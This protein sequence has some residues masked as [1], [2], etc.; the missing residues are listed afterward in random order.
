M[1]TSIET[2]A[3]AASNP[4]PYICV[5]NELPPEFMIVETIRIDI[6]KPVD[7]WRCGDKWFDCPLTVMVLWNSGKSDPARAPVQAPTHWREV[8]Q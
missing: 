6:L 5:A 2:Q 7:L 3:R 8:H 4:D 1:K